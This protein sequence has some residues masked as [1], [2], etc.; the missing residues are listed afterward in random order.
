[1]ELAL[2]GQG[3]GLE[4]S[5]PE[6]PCQGQCPRRVVPCRSKIGQRVPTEI[7]GVMRD[8]LCTGVPYFRS[9]AN[10]VHRLSEA[11]ANIPGKPPR[12]RR[13]RPIG[14]LDASESMPLTDLDAL[15]EIMLRAKHPADHVLAVAEPSQ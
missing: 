8:Y 14:N 2:E 7:C 13:H 5:R 11:T 6:L 4:S 9:S 12:E 15:L 10:R 3:L 1:M